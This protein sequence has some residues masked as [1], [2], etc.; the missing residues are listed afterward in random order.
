MNN[1]YVDL[2][3]YHDCLQQLREDLIDCEGPPDWFEKTN[4]NIVCQ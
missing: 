4:K 2:I 1:F 3:D